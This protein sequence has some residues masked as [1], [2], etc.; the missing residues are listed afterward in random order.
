MREPS[1]KEAELL[2]VISTRNNGSVLARFEDWAALQ[3]PEIV[4]HALRF[5]GR[6]A[7]S[8]HLVKPKT[9]NVVVMPKR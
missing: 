2:R 8:L 5:V 3:A 9:S 1:K 6:N 4:D 7:G